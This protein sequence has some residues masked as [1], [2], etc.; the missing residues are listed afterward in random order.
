[1]SEDKVESFRFNLRLAAAI[2]LIG[3]IC[4]LVVGFL[5][6]GQYLNANR[7][8]TSPPVQEITPTQP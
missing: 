5:I 4:A 6:V 1:M 7:N 8:N 3:V 2:I